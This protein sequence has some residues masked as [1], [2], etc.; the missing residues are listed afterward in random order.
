LRRRT[1][2][3]HPMNLA[4]R[5]LRGGSAAKVEIGL[6]GIADRP[7]AR[8]AGQVQKRE[9]LPTRDVDGHG[10]GLGQRLDLLRPRTRASA[11]SGIAQHGLFSHEVV[12]LPIDPVPRRRHSPLMGKF[13]SDNLSVLIDER[14]APPCRCYKSFD[15]SVLGGVP[16]Q[17]RRTVLVI[18]RQMLV[19]AGQDAHGADQ[20]DD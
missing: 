19:Q 6:P 10:C 4:V 11:R 1:V 9:P 12:G 7:A 13:R 15:A 20:D 17:Q 14:R 18:W 8:S 5:L 3:D 2:C 16:L